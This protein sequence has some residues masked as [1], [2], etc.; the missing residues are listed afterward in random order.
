[1]KSL[2]VNGESE[3]ETPKVRSSLF[4]PITFFLVVSLCYIAFPYYAIYS[5]KS[6]IE[7]GD[8]EKLKRAY[9]F[10]ALKS[11]LK[12]QLNAVAAKSM[13]DNASK[14]TIGSGIAM[15]LLPTLIE[16][17]L[18]SYLNPASLSMLIKKA[19]KSEANELTAMSSNTGLTPIIWTVS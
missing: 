4:W 6:T 1:M 13:L 9:D 12:D 10:E 17:T 5:L 2:L 8:Y 18:D 19:N 14:N 16:S 7:T 15:L 11:S 3:I